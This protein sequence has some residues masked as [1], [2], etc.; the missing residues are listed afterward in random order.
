MAK[1]YNIGNTAEFDK[2][3]PQIEK[4]LDLEDLGLI[5]IVMIKGFLISVIFNGELLTPN[6]NAR[7]PFNRNKKACYINPFNGNIWVGYED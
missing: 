5:N 4:N 7:N 3:A 6:L 1:W 2:G